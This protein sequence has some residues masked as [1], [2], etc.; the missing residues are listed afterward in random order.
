[1]NYILT[2]SLYK[3]KKYFINIKYTIKFRHKP[4]KS[5]SKYFLLFD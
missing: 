3:T 1:M 5:L 2:G 4:Q